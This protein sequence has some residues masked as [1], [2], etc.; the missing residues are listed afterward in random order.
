M[1]KLV[2]AKCPSCGAILKLSGEEEKI[3]CEYCN[4]IIIVDEAVAC[5][6]LKITGNVSVEGITTNSELI[7]SANEL[8]DMGEYL[9]A[10][11]KFLEFSEK[12]PEDYQGWLGLL[13]C[14]T[15]N[16]T[17][18][19]NNNMF[20]NDVKN[21]YNHFKDT[22]SKETFEQYFEIIDRYF[23]PEKYKIREM[24]EKIN[25]HKQ[26]LEEKKKQ[27]AELK[28]KRRAKKKTNNSAYQKISETLDKGKEK[29][30]NLKIS[31]DSISEK[32]DKVI[33]NIKDLVLKIIN[34]FWYFF[35]G[36]VIFAGLINDASVAEKILTVL[37]GLSL[38][39]CIYTTIGDKI[40]ISK[41]Y[42]FILRV[43][44]PTILLIVLVS[45]IPS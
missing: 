22:A 13:I 44:V 42:L 6:K 20:E 16:F 8:L 11:R 36:M 30:K 33:R 34:G 29:I 14:R 23:E 15:R 24:Q 27:R 37:V 12:C 18:K 9:K 31:S 41:G 4:N 2:S 26:E 25:K 32:T 40:K 1:S 35:G 38:F 39:K 21:Y 10:K 43:L 7:E 3:K 19:D 5:Y 17:I 28:E 45:I